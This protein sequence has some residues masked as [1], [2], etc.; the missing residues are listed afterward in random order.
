[1]YMFF[2]L[3]EYNVNALWF[4]DT[5]PKDEKNIACYKLIQTVTQSMISNITELKM[6]KMFIYFNNVIILSICIS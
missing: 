6:V 4:K 1:M 2:A 5:V 3:T